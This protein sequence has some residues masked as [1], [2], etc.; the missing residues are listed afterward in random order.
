M[1]IKERGRYTVINPDHKQ[2][3]VTG[4]EDNDANEYTDGFYTSDSDT[5][6]PDDAG[7][8]QESKL[9]EAH[10]ATLDINQSLFS[11]GANIS[12]SGGMMNPEKFARL[13][14][15]K[16]KKKKLRSQV[17]QNSHSNDSE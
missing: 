3:R 14:L 10:S 13:A 9:V 1:K 17:L 15:A 8:D 2:K 4:T 6:V 7:G 16:E 12:D 11:N 5:F